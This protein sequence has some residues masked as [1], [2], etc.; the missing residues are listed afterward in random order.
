MMEEQDI[1]AWATHRHGG[2]RVKAIATSYAMSPSLAEVVDASDDSNIYDLATHEEIFALVANDDGEL[3][4]E[5]MRVRSKERD[6]IYN[7]L[8]MDSVRVLNQHNGYEPI[9]GDGLIYIDGVTGKVITRDE[10]NTKRLTQDVYEGYPFESVFTSV[11]PILGTGVGQ[12]QFDLKNITNLGLRLEA[13]CGGEIE[14]AGKPG[15]KEP[16]RYDD[17]AGEDKSPVI[18]DGMA[19]FFNL[20]A[21]N[22]KP[23]G[24]NTRDGRIT[25]VQDRPYPFTLISYEADYATEGEARYDYAAR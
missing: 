7:S 14:S 4:V 17:E 12:G 13:S 10:A 5:R 9:E 1:M 23:I 21:A 11:Y 24:V 6:T 22:G 25:I 18:V 20:N 16:I 19:R 2:G 8:C 3:W 15:D